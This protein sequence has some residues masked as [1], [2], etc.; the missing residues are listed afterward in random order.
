MSFSHF[1]C[2]CQKAIGHIVRGTVCTKIDVKF[3]ISHFGVCDGRFVLILCC[4]CHSLTN[5]P[6]FELL[7]VLTAQ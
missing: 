1:A 5:T 7:H 3:L 2:E 4:L 6:S